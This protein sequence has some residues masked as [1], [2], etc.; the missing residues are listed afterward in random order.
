MLAYHT[1]T[2]KWNFSFKTHKCTKVWPGSL[3]NH[4]NRRTVIETYSGKSGA[5][6]RIQPKERT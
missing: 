2:D 3:R 1:S 4:W 6:E 5:P